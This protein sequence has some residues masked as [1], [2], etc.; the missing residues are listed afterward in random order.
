MA[1]TPATSTKRHQL[2]QAIS[3]LLAP[4]ACVE[5]VIAVGSVG[6]GEARPDSDTDALVF[7]DPIDHF[8]VP[9]ESIWCPWDDSFHSIFSGDSRVQEEGVQLD[10]ELLDFKEWSDPDFFVSE[11]QRAGLAAGWIAFDRNDKVTELV[12]ERTHYDDATRVRKIDAAV[13][14]LDQHLK[15]GTPERNWETLGALISADRLNAAYADL[16]ELL[17]AYNRC[18]RFWPERQMS[19][20]MRL[21]W[22]PNRF[23]V[24][25]I[26]AM[27][28]PSLG[29]GGFINRVQILRELFREVLAKLID[30]GFYASN[31]IGEA[32][33]RIHQEEPGRAWNMDQWNARRVKLS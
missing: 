27:N 32:F 30:E 25:V 7:M 10:F 31:P 16:V 20:L 26:V 9:R 2:E 28:A 13:T 17:Y 23:E 18:W 12:R 22:L 29:R 8:V 6:L 3:Q 4:V 15:A 5:G 19:Y 11:P 21:P 1:M 33:M 14:H 24:R